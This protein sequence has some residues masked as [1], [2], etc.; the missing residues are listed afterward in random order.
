V[1]AENEDVLQ[2]PVDVLREQFAATNERDFTRAM[3][4]YADEVV[5]VVEEGFLN[6]G[7]FEGKE[8]V[9]EWYGDWFRAF[10]RDYRF[11]IQEIRELKPGLVFMTATYGGSGRASGARVDDQRS[12][13]YRVEDGKITRIQF[14]LT[15]EGAIEAA[16][17][18]EWSR[19]ET[20]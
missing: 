8:A 12:Y 16:S 2:D 14:F 19:A 3:T 10:G 18:P 9:G 17:L 6:T 7:T 15:S 5:L 1:A 20:D 4:Y 13:L 11:E